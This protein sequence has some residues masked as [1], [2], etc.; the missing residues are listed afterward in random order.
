MNYPRNQT[1]KNGKHIILTIPELQPQA[2]AADQ[3]AS[4]TRF[5]QNKVKGVFV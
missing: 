5:A 1:R 4:V 2:L 3:S